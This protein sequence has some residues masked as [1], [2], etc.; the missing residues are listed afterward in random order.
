MDKIES[1]NATVRR[2]GKF[3]WL[4]VYPDNDIA[5]IQSPILIPVNVYTGIDP[6][7]KAG[8]DSDDTVFFSVGLTPTGKFIILDIVAEK[9]PIE[10][11]P[12]RVVNYLDIWS[13]THATIE[14]YA[15]QLSLLSTVLKQMRESGKSHVVFPFNENKSKTNK[16]KDGLIEPIN[17][18]RF[19]YVKGCPNIAK[20]KEQGKR[21]SGG[22]TPHDDTLDGAFL[23][24]VEDEKLGKVLF[25]PYNIPVSETLT[26]LKVAKEKRTRKSKSKYNNFMSR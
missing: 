17:N 19:S 2:F 20:F 1:I 16:Y 3:T 8:I 7:V 22:V 5:H 13:P 9:I 6:S 15:Y 26:R 10:E 12:I 18:N 4:E 24:I 11:Q 23:A 21:F 25:P 14:T